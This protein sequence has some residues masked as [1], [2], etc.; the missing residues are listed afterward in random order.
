MKSRT[1][2]AFDFDGTIITKDSL[3]LFILFSTK[4]G[5]LISRAIQMLPHF[6]LFKLKI[7]PN[8]V[9]KAKLCK[10]FFTGYTSGEFDRIGNDFAKEIDKIVNPEALKKIEWHKE[11]GHEVIIISASVENW[12]RPWAI[13][14]GIDKVLATQLETSDG[15]LTGKLLS[16]NCHGEEKV[17][18]LIAAYPNRANYTL[19]A[20]GDTTGDKE[21][22]AMSD[23]PFYQRFN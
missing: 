15:V 11:M 1:I 2:A 16:E 18:R 21:L 7:I 6:I 14:H 5:R 13:Q 3:P 10:L 9:A 23:F 20:Y 17:N 4:F 22:L 12:I 8:H 19:Y